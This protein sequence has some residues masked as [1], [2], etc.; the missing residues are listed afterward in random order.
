MRV[1]PMID[2]HAKDL[3][4]TSRVVASWAS[5][6]ATNNNMLRYL[7]C[8]DRQIENR[9]VLEQAIL[10][11]AQIDGRRAGVDV[12]EIR[13]GESAI[14]PEQLLARQREQ[15][16]GQLRAAYV[17]EQIAQEQRQKTEQA[18][19][20]ADQQRD[21]V[22]AQISV[23]TGRLAQDR[24]QAEGHAER[25][26]LEELAAGQTVQA[27]VLGKDSVLKLQMLKLALDLLATHP[28]LRRR[29]L[30]NRVAR[31]NQRVAALSSEAE[32]AAKRAEAAARRAG[33][34]A[35]SRAPGPEFLDARRVP[36]A[37]AR[38]FLA[39]L[40]ERM[41]QGPAAGA[42]DRLVF[43]VDNLDA[44]PAGD[45]I[46][47]IDT[48]QSVLGMGSIG[49]MALDIARL[50]DS[51]GGP[52]EA[53]RR[54][55]KWLQVVVNLPRRADLDGERLVAK[56]LSTDGQATPAPIAAEIGSALV[57]PLSAAETALLTALAP[58]AAHS[59]RGAKRF[60]NAYRLARCSS[61]P[62]PIIALMQAVAFADDDAR[63]AMHNRLAG[64]VDE[65]GDFEGPEPLAKAVKSARAAN[66]GA[67][68]I[69]DARSPA[70]TPSHC[71]PSGGGAGAT[72][73]ASASGSFD[74]LQP[75]PS[76]TTRLTASV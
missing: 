49:V 31:L 8:D 42:P 46:A 59:P 5:S 17:Q 73:S 18:R 50:L 28:E 33:G 15:L 55:D 22:T 14:P 3:R 70:A 76:A 64:G 56:L 54:L 13:L 37:A 27:E 12:K 71:D 38:A 52:A 45:A 19:A 30:D 66:K 7:R 11:R 1:L 32:A 24:R 58:L 16:A 6:A 69:A 57:E 10:E 63:T 36:A 26:F 67:I 21:L 23:Q 35:A 65:L 72:A 40:A 39:A 75:P 2:A 60:L 51:L 62:R 61:A 29:D 53:R 4:I 43:V 9:T 20:T 48:A 34:K 41:S 74:W 68:S 44:L 25:L 47:W